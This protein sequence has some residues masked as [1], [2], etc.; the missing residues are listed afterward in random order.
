V[1]VTGVVYLPEPAGHPDPDAL[2]RLHE[3]SIG[4]ELSGFVVVSRAGAQLG[5]DPDSAHR[6]YVPTLTP[7]FGVAGRTPYPAPPW[8]GTTKTCRRL[9]PASHRADRLVQALV[10]AVEYD[11][12]ERHHR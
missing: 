11:E 8:R 2:R 1:A 4:R 10:R 6:A 5:V 12:P 7:S 3:Q 9:R